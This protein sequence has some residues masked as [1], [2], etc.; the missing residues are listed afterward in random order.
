MNFSFRITTVAGKYL[1]LQLYPIGNP[2]ENQLYF[3]DLEKHG[4]IREKIPLKPVYT[5][6]INTEF[7][8]SGKMMAKC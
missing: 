7:N 5:G 2:N 8:V 4:E 6:D 3:A 1:V